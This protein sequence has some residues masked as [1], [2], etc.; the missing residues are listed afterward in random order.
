[1]Q[2]AAPLLWLLAI[3]LVLA[4]VAGTILP[5]LPG[6]PLVF[7]GLLLAAWADGFQKVG[8]FPLT[9]IGILML[10][11]LGADLLASSLGAKRVGASWL[12]VAGAG[13][14]TLAGIFLGIPG[15]LLGPLVG[16]F[17]GELLAR[18]DWTQARK[19]GLGTWIGFLLG[20]VLKIA[21][22]FG[23]IGIFALAYVV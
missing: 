23:M 9:L 21:L 16:A 20:T 22:I 18:R 14:G 17:L 15:L 7:L 1:M 6:A 3:V 5:A 12:A 19:G 11:T 13:V 8:W 10:L 4:G 2:E